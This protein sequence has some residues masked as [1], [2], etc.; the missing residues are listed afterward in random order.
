LIRCNL[1]VLLAERN[2]KSSK[3]SKDT[4]ISRTTITSLIY[5]HSQGIQFDTIN[6][7]CNYLKITPGELFEYLPFDLI[8]EYKSRTRHQ[9]DFDMIT[10]Y[11]GKRREFELCAIIEDNTVTYDEKDELPESIITSV[12]IQVMYLDDNEPEDSKK[13]LNEILSKLTRGFLSEIEIKITDKILEYY[14]QEA[15]MDVYLNWDSN[16]EIFS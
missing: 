12:N 2:L 9:M 7:L 10:V 6:T 16:F 1:S 3:V 8:I 4:G 14:D 15:D 5:N 13:Y 11:N